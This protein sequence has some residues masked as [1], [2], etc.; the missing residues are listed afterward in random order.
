MLL[1]D[2]PEKTFHRLLKSVTWTEV[3][4]AF[5]IKHRLR[6]FISR[7]AQPSRWIMSVRKRIASP[8]TDDRSSMQESDDRGSTP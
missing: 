4:G 1:Q 7:V 8:C 5:P 3:E 2:L 6:R